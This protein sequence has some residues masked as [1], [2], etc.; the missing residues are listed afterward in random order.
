MRTLA[1]AAL[2]MV[3]CEAQ[4]ATAV[5]ERVEVA[6]SP[7]VCV[8]LHLSG[9]T[10]PRAGY[11]AAPDRVFVD[12][13]ETTLGPEAPMTLESGGPLRNVRTAQ[14]DASTVRV[15]LDLDRRAPYTVH[16]NGPTVTVTLVAPQAGDDSTEHT[17]PPLKP[18]ETSAYRPGDRVRPRLFL[19][20]PPDFLE[21]PSRTTT[22]RTSP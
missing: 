12:L 22:R 21:H 2:V 13:P 15:V 16:A 6:T 3:A 19:D 18:S 9:P 11:L 20:Y 5:L 8:T 4:A 7:Q 1:A 17:R 14:R 10:T